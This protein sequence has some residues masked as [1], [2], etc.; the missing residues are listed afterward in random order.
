[1]AAE[2]EVAGNRPTDASPKR[3]EEMTR[4]EHW[5]AA[6]GCALSELMTLIPFQF[7]AVMLPVLSHHFLDGKQ[8]GNSMLGMYQLFC[9]IALLIILK[10]GALHGWLIQGGLV[11]S[12]VCMGAFSPAFFYGPVACRI[13]LIHIIL[14]LLGTCNAALQAA[15]FARAAI[16]PRNYVGTTSIG[17]ATA[18][19]VAFVVTAILMNGVFDMDNVNDVKWFSCICCGISVVMCILSIVYMH[20]FL[21]AKVCVQSVNNALNGGSDG[22]ATQDDT[23]TIAA[24]LEEPKRRQNSASSGTLDESL[25]PPRPWLTMMRGSFWELLSLFLV[26]F[27]TFSLFPKVGPVSFNFEGKGPSK[28]VLLFGMQFVGDFLGRSCLKLTSLH[29][30]FSFLFLSRNA[31]IAASFIRLVFYIPFCMAMKMENTPFIN[32]FAWLMILQLLLAF[33]LGWVGTL[34]L[35]YC[36]MSVTRMS[37]KA[38][39]GS[40]STIVLAVAIGVGLYIALAF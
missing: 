29:R 23:P 35:I 3:G 17:Q 38:R 25:L 30:I 13:A 20:V 19:L 40:L 8:L 16:L 39:M 22:K 28:M 10:V 37:E 1:M 6:T 21:N 14:G 5:M 2:T 12:L 31:T 36:S 24:D 11:L 27:I 26:F 18:G 34:T 7:V 9:V 15:G 33:T 32:N 4:R